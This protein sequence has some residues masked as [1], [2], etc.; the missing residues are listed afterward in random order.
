MFFLL[1]P[2]IN[3]A[4]C[5]NAGNPIT[6]LHLRWILNH[7]ELF[8]TQLCQIPLAMAWSSLTGTCLQNCSMTRKACNHCLNFSVFTHTWGR[9][10]KETEILFIYLHINVWFQF[11]FFGQNLMLN[12]KIQNLGTLQ[13]SLRMAEKYLSML[14]PDTSYAE[15]EQKFQEIGLERGWG[16]NAKHVLEMIQLLLDLLQAPEASILERFLG[17]IP[18]VFNVV[19]FTPH[20][21][22][23]QN[24]VLGYPDTGGQV[25]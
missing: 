15:F 19:I 6:T 11:L 14:D 2:W 1:I 3:V 18:R 4:C 7:S 8:L 22:F 16:D 23:A 9:Y 21:Y 25:S 24:N 12:E 10:A 5:F 13:S 17:K 20:G